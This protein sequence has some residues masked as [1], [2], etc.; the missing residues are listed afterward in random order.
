M[1]TKIW[2]KTQ[3]ID[4]SS[5]LIKTKF[6]T[7]ILSKC[8]LILTAVVCFMGCKKDPVLTYLEAVPFTGELTA[9]AANVVL[10]ADNNDETVIS[11]SW[12]AVTFKIEA[13]V[14][15]KLQLSLPSDTIG[16][17][18]WDKAV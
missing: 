5:L 7:N 15:Y 14:S 8:L 9:S 18:L 16:N 6:M 3:V 17:T 1:P 13:P 11:F 10:S 2:C 12:P 4:F